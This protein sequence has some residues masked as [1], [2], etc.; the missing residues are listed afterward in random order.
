[1]WFIVT[2]I[3]TLLRAIAFLKHGS[4]SACVCM[5]VCV[6]VRERERYVCACEVVILDVYNKATY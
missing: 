2:T 3:S 4:L 1:M 5:R 6:C